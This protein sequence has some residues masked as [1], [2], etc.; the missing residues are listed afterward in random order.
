LDGEWRSA[1][2][3]IGRGVIMFENSA[4]IHHYVNNGVTREHL[5]SA[6]NAVAELSQSCKDAK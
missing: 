1:S 6:R 4:Y 2:G 3:E 5:A